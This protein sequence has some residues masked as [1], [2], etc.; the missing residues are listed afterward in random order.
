MPSRRQIGAGGDDQMGIAEVEDLIRIERALPEDLDIRQLGELLQAM[1]AHPAPGAGM[2]Q[3]AFARDPAA[4]LA[5]RL[6]PGSPD[7]PAVPGRGRIRA[8]PAP[9]PPPG[10]ALS[11]RLGAMRSGCQPR[12]HSSPMV[13]FWVQRI[14]DMVISPLMQIL[15]PMHSRMSSIRPSSI[16]RG[17]K[18]SAME[19]RAAP[20]RSSRPL[21]IWR[22]MASGEVKRPTPT[23]GLLVSDLSPA[24]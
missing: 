2:R 19:G 14:G 21:R 15:Q 13:G 16:F 3:A 11:L 23:T 1:V 9:P 12:R 22:T 8:R 20:I 18:G 7:S 4:E 10:S 6:P 17:R 5:A 24:I